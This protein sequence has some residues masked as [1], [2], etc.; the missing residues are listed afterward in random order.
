MIVKIGRSFEKD[1]S[2][3][4]NVKVLKQIFNLVEDVKKAASI[5]AINNIKKLKGYKSHYRIRIGDYRAGLH[6]NDNTVEFIRFLHRKDIYK[7]FP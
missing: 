3:L 6:I 7:R 1:V 5:E 4:K 2:V